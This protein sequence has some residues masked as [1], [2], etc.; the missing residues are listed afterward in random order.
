MR[1]G[2]ERTLSVEEPMLSNCDVVEDSRESVGLK[3]DQASQS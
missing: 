1:V 2:P 3:G